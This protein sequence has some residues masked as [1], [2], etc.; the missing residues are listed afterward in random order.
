MNTASALMR[1][2]ATA[3]DHDSSVVVAM[4]LSGISWIISAA[5]P[6]V[7]R[8]PKRTLEVGNG[9]LAGP[10]AGEPADPSRKSEPL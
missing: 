8:R 4:E 9:E 3:F 10:V 1:K 6:G 2:P 7:D 5:V